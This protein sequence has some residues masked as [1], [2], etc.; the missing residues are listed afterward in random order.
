M[1]V[2]IPP[3]G[4]AKEKANNKCGGRRRNMQSRAGNWIGATE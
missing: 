2:E 1:R 3:R 4:E